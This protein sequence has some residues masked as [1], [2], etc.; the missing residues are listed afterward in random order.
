[1][2]Y[3]RIVVALLLT[4]GVLNCFAADYPSEKELWKV[5]SS[6]PGYKTHANRMFVHPGKAIA[7]KMSSRD[8]RS[9]TAF[10]ERNKQRVNVRRK[11]LNRIWSDFAPGEK[12]LVL[13]EMYDLFH[14]KHYRATVIT[15]RTMYLVEINENKEKGE[16]FRKYDLAPETVAA[17]CAK[18]SAVS[19]KDGSCELVDSTTY[20]A[21]VSVKNKD[22][23]WTS[24]VY[25]STNFV[26]R[27]AP[28]HRAEYFAKTA[29][30]MA[31]LSAV[32]F[33][34]DSSEIPQVIIKK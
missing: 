12:A 2:K 20:P 7:P 34:K 33:V 23:K 1:M 15:Q 29:D 18:A 10:N 30:I 5:F 17:I 22:G 25:V 32:E 16:I 11:T 13:C 19:S 27:K 8:K 4:A 9:A 31:F 14:G 28:E 26:W 6:T 21:F 3:C 24:S